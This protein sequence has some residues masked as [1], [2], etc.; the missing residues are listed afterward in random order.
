MASNTVLNTNFEIMKKLR[1]YLTAYMDSLFLSSPQKQHNEGQMS[2]KLHQRGSPK[3]W[4][5]YHI[6]MNKM[7]YP[8]FHPKRRI[9]HYANILWWTRGKA[10]LSLFHWNV[11]E[12][13]RKTKDKSLRDSRSLS[14][15]YLRDTIFTEKMLST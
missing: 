10:F 1:C 3:L 6:G 15:R 14:W 7:L 8:N 13:S 2:T 5:I 4:D 12:C 11:K 9:S